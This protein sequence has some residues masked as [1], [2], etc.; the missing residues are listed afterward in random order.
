MFKELIWVKKNSLTKE[1]CKSV[2]DK[3]ET[4][5]YREEGKVNQNNP[6]IDTKVKLTIDTGVTNNIAWK[7]EDEILYKALGIALEEYN[8]YIIKLA[9]NYTPHNGGTLYPA[10][11][12]EIKDTGYKVQKYEP[13]GYYHWHHDWCMH[14]GWS[15]IYT[16]IWYLNTVKEEDGGWTEFIDG[17]KIQPKCGSILF[18]PATWTYVHRGYTTKVPKYLCNGWIYAKP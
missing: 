15:R 13:N 7:K 3:F 1:F 16:Y 12:Y 6:R 8:D 17:T 4:D 18:F 10:S 2:I 5:P 11:A 9:K 14:K